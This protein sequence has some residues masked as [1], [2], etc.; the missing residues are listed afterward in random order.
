MRSMGQGMRSMGRRPRGWFLPAE[1]GEAPRDPLQRPGQ[2]RGTGSAAP[3]RPAPAGRVP[4]EVVADPGEL[5]GD[6][7]VGLG[8]DHAGVGGL[9]DRAEA[10]MS[11]A[12]LNCHSRFFQTLR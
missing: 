8:G 3:R 10:P 5:A 12:V 4:A 11:G 1:L 9:G 7:P 6:V 2:G